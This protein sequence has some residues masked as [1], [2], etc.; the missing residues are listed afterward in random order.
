MGFVEM[1]SGAAIFVRLNSGHGAR[2]IVADAGGDL[3][4]LGYILERNPIA[5]L[6]RKGV[7]L[8]VFDRADNN[9]IFLGV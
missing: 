8:E 7:A 3:E 6:D 2:V 4:G 9:S 5:A 1:D